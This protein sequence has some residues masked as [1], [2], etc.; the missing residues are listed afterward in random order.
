MQESPDTREPSIQKSPPHRKML[1]RIL[2]ARAQ[3][4]ELPR[5]HAG[6]YPPTRGL[7]PLPLSVELG[8]LGPEP[9]SHP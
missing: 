2:E 3:I 6:T 7:G 9:A 5:L 4:S 8:A 1:S